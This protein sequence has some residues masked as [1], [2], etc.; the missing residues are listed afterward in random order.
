LVEFGELVGI[1]FA[2]PMRVQA[3]HREGRV[4]RIKRPSVAKADE[5][6]FRVE[7]N[8]AS[9][10]NPHMRV[11]H[12]WHTPAYKQPEDSQETTEA[13]HGSTLTKADG[14]AWPARLPFKNSGCVQGPLCWSSC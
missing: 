6:A 4:G 14:N 11:C 7:H 1:G 8:F 12:R 10:D 2:V 9:C 3:R 5:F 13:G